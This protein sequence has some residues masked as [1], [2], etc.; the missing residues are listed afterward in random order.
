MRF[1]GRLLFLIVVVVA[2]IIAAFFLLR[3]DTR[4][5]FGLAVAL[6]PGP[7]AYGYTCAPGGAFAYIDATENTFLYQD[8]G[9]VTVALPFPFTFYGTIY[10]EVH[11]NSNGTLHFGAPGFADYAN[12]CLQPE[13]A[14]AM[15]DMIAPYWDD[16][17]LTYA[18]YLET[19]VVGA[20]PNRIFVVEWDDVPRF[21]SDLA[22]TV[23]FAVQLFEATQDIVFLY[24]DVT[25]V[26]GSRGGSAT[27]GLQS[28]E[29]GVSLQYSC[30]QPALSDAVG[31][32][33]PHPDEANADLGL[34]APV[35]RAD[36][37]TLAMKGPTADLLT[38]LN[39][40]QPNA[41]NDLQATWRTQ[42]PA[43]LATWHELDLTGNG[44]DELLVLWRGAS[45]EPTLTQLAVLGTTP[46]NG[47]APLFDQRLT[48]RERPIM[49]VTLAAAVDLTGDGIT[50]ALLH[51]ARQG[52][53]FVLTAVSG[54]LLL[55]PLADQCDG[56]LRVVE[57]AVG[58][59]PHIVR[60]G[61]T[62]PGRLTMAWDASG[63]VQIDD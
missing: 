47:F 35:A 18:G 21:G 11:L 8:D 55:Y 5:Q 7:D 30:N 13:P 57:A 20:A 27:I 44:R 51:D 49:A 61:C 25:T 23:T 53:V 4:A 16:L 40:R 10:T 63:F 28:A 12:V 45:G 58:G 29:Q 17:D 37:P 48:T 15:G 6:C 3:R 62:M 19:A 2:M 60:D 41:L 24:Q 32:H 42:R 14:A 22:D 54:D 31:I 52:R 1:P 39:Q 56:R 46:E 36:T 34:A 9:L 38:R 50:D 43:R 59:V 26:E 33:F